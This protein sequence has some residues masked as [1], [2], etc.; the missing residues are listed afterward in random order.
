MPFDLATAKP[1]VGTAS[2]PKIAAHFDL[3]TA[4][5]VAPKIDKID[6]P[7]VMDTRG[8]G[9]AALSLITSPIAQSLG[10]W[11]GILSGGNP[12][13]V[14]Q[15]ERAL[16]YQPRSAMGKEISKLFSMPAR[17]ISEG[18]HRAGNAVLSA[19]HSPLA[20]TVADTAIQGLPII[21]GAKLSPEPDVPPELDP[22]LQESMK[23]GY[24]IPPAQANP[25]LLNRALQGISGGSKYG[26]ISALASIKN[27]EITNALVREDLGLSPGERISYKSLDDLRNNAGKAYK[28]VSNIGEV[29]TD[30]I[31]ARGLNDLASSISDA[32]KSFP[33]LAKT[34]LMDIIDAL[35]VNSFDAGSGVEQV[36]ILRDD[37]SKAYR[38]GDTALGKIYR[39]G[40]NLIDE[41]IE[42]HVEQNPDVL[43]PDVAK[44]YLEARTKIAKIRA[45]ESALNDATGNID[46]RKFAKML[47]K[48]KPLT[49]GMAMAGRFSQHFPFSSFPAERTGGVPL[50]ALDV[51]AG[52]GGEAVSRSKLGLLAS[53]GRP[54]LRSLLLSDPYQNLM[55]RGRVAT[56]PA[57]YGAALGAIPLSQ[58]VGGK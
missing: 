18:A 47:D 27:Q 24:K 30:A 38:S 25:T 3:A 36:K 56:V 58:Q 17:L 37:A 54:G 12:H 8:L 4:K 11:A 9:E 28:A 1:I 57:Y 44:N 10:G 23:A 7:S 45:A 33:K 35:R 46:A 26:K 39:T 19:T 16:A 50:S 40:A 20:A 6:H 43:A 42:R 13:V 49:G 53:L 51:L 34:S 41:Q 32:A 2:A 15:T 21:A 48:R 29:P 31:Y 22:V 5:P 55:L 14:H 52:V